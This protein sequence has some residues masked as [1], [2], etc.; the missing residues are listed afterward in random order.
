EAVLPVAAVT[1]NKLYRVTAAGVPVI[2]LK[3]GETFYALAATCTHAGGPLDEGTLTN[4]VVQCPWHGA[5]FRLRD[6]HT[7]T[8]PATINQPRYDVRVRDGQIELKRI[9]GH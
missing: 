7:L 9:G 2:L 4:G 8:W 6:G 5:R 1:E 3:M